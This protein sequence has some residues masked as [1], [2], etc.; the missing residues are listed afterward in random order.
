MVS[1]VSTQPSDEKFEDAYSRLLGSSSSVPSDKNR[2]P[3][4][5]AHKSCEV[6]LTNLIQ[7]LDTEISPHIIIYNNLI[8][9]QENLPKNIQ[10]HLLDRDVPDTL[11]GNR[12]T[13]RQNF[14]Q[15][16]VRLAS[17][18]EARK[19]LPG[20]PTIEQRRGKNETYYKFLMECTEWFE[21]VLQFWNRE[22]ISADEEEVRPDWE[23]KKILNE[24]RKKF[25]KV[26]EFFRDTVWNDIQPPSVEQYEDDLRTIIAWLSYRGEPKVSDPKFFEISEKQMNRFIQ[27][28]GVLIQDLRKTKNLFNLILDEFVLCERE[29]ASKDQL[30]IYLG[31][32]EDCFFSVEQSWAEKLR[33]N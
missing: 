29:G 22:D 9:V 6:W 27:S 33:S 20:K 14:I 23:I 30:F 15:A 5:E 3:Q 21:K 1:P 17:A 19:T 26:S 25:G 28:K 10:T 13:V 24:Q 4:L 11:F 18:A 2:D 8:R 12:G 32:C 7:L 16:K 31:Q